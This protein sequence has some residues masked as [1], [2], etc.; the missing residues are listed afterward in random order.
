MRSLLGNPDLLHKIGEVILIYYIKMSLP[1]FY[2]VDL[3]MSNGLMPAARKLMMLNR[4]LIVPGE[5]HAMLN[6]GVNL[7]LLVLRPRESMVLQGS[8]IMSAPGIL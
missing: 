3:E 5:E 7:C 4:L 2:V 8:C 6:I 1:H